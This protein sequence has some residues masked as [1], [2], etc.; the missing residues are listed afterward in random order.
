MRGTSNGSRC[1]RCFR[2]WST[3]RPGPAASS[4]RF[5]ASTG[6]SMSDGAFRS[7]PNGLGELV[8]ALARAVPKESLRS[9][10]AVTRIDEGDGFTIQLDGK[11]S[12][13]ARS[14]ILAVPAFAAADLLRSIDPDSERRVPIDSVSVFGDRCLRLSSGGRRPRPRG[15]RVRRPARRRDQHHRRCVDFVEVAAARARRPGAAARISRRRARSRRAV[16]DRR[17]ARGRSARR[18]ERGFSASA[19]TPTLTRVYRWS[20]SSPQQEVGHAELVRRL[21]ATLARHPGLVHLRGRVPRRR[22]SGLRRRRARHCR[23]GC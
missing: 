9:A 3:P 2:G 11:P 20:R 23:G 13:R 12:I 22:Y 5:D 6:R 1:A 7:F 21:D 16:E 14:V 10:L 15:H 17:R 19:A 4:G 8:D 18:L